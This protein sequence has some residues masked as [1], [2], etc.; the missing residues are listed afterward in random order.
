[1]FG[2]HLVEYLEQWLPTS[3]F[4]AFVGGMTLSHGLSKTIGKYK[5]LH[6]DS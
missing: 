5:Y 6:Y 3:G 4:D 2:S 1:M